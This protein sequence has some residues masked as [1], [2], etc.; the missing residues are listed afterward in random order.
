MPNPS[1]LPVGNTDR[2]MGAWFKTS[3][4]D[5][6]ILM[7]MSYGSPSTNR[8]FG[9]YVVDGKVHCDSWNIAFNGGPNIADNN[10]HFAM[11]SHSSSNGTVLYV[12]GVAVKTSGNIFTTSSETPFQIAR[13]VNNTGYFI[14]AIDDVRVYN[15]ALSESE[16]K[17]LFNS[18]I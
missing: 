16:I 9:L 6:R 4:S 7:L 10:W 14:G 8:A 11:V 15:Y 18:G 3:V 5:N 2:S 13:W 12:D 17:A 1:G